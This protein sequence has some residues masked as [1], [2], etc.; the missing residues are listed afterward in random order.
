MKDVLSALSILLLLVV[1]SACSPSSNPLLPTPA[2]AGPAAPFVISGIVF[3]VNAGARAPL[4]GA[5][6]E[7]A[8]LGETVTDADG[9]YELHGVTRVRSLLVTVRKA[10]YVPVGV[11]VA[12]TNDIHVDFT[13][14]GTISYTL[15]GVVSDETP[16]GAVP[17]E[18]V[19]IFIQSC[20]DPPRCLVN[21][22]ASVT[23]DA[24]GAYRFAGLFGGQNSAAIWL[25]RNGHDLQD[26]P[27]EPTPCDG[28][29]RILTIEGDT[30]LDILLHATAR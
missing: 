30:R 21:V 24:S 26:T 15:S 28:C 1:V 4:P 22:Q 17:A 16:N 19:L 7:T 23:T 5:I 29:F 2:P 27:P 8:D 18:G 11:T 13:L 12:L 9:R 20:Q 25:S 3:G 10:G 14:L 6:V